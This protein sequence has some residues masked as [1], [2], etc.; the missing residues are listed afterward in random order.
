MY[1]GLWPPHCQ[2]RYISI[3]HQHLLSSLQICPHY[4]NH[5]G[6][7]VGKVVVVVVVVVGSV[8]KVVHHQIHQNFL[9][10]IHHSYT[11]TTTAITAT[12]ATTTATTATTKSTSTKSTTTTTPCCTWMATTD[13]SYTNTF[14]TA[15]FFSPM[16][17]AHFGENGCCM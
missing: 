9:R 4:Y 16:A 11:V 12:T 2:D 3:C 10:Q 1:L 15:T 17:C 7:G 14:G 6:V 8:G 5:F 13:Q